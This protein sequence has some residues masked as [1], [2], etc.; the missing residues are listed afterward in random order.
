MSLEHSQL[1][2]RA[3][4]R[5]ITFGII[6]G[7]G[8]TGRAVASELSKSHNGHILIGGRDLAKGTALAR[9]LGSRVSAARLDVLDPHSLDDFSSRCS[10]VI[11]C[12]G[13]VMALRDRVAQAAFRARCHYI[14]V[15]AMSLV[16][17]RMLLHARE[18]AGLGLSFVLSAGWMPGLSEFLPAYAVAQARTQMDA[19]ESL[20][21][22]FGDSGEWSDNAL[23]DGVHYLRQI[24]FRSPHYFCKGN[25]TRAKISQASC[26][27]D[28]GTPVGAGRFSLFSTPELEELGRRLDDC[29]VFPYSYLSG[30]RTAVVG[31]LIALFPLPQSTAVRMLRKVFRR[32]RLPVDGFVVAHVVGRS[33]ERRLRFTAQIVYRN[34]GDYWINGLVPALVARMIANEERVRRGIHYLA[35]AVNPISFMAELRKSGVEQTENLQPCQ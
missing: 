8:A 5:A 29:D 3:T 1:R 35:D 9:E 28:L 14:D 17:E 25:W 22:Y 6:G 7:Y 32:N 2:S 26:K 21:I 4:D 24:G 15:A 23:R 19:L 12:A 10:I 16:R 13:P 20:S 30:F 34:R 27:V 31:T 11:N 33:R 18:I